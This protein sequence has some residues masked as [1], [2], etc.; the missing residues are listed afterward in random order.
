MAQRRALTDFHQGGGCKTWAGDSVTDELVKI[1]M[2]VVTQLRKRSGR[3][4]KAGLVR[5]LC[6]VGETI[7][8]VLAGRQVI[9]TEDY[10]D[11]EEVER[12]RLA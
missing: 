10:P 9:T 5:A 2:S 7:A 12:W 6:N 3:R 1:H 4:T 8:N 11:F